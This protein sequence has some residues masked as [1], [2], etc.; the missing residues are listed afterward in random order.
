[1][2][3]V[4]IVMGVFN[5]SDT[6]SKS[7]DSIINQTFS[8]WEFII[9]DDGSTDNTYDLLLQ[10]AH[11]DPRIIIL[12]NEKNMG[13]PY[14]L[15][16]CIAHSSG[17]FI[18][19]QDGDD[20]S[21]P[22][23]LERQVKYLE[24]NK[25]CQF[26]G[27]A[28]YLFDQKGIWGE[29]I[30]K[31]SAPKPIDLRKGPNFAHPTIIFRKEALYKASLYRA[32]QDTLRVE[33]YDLYMR[34]YSLGLYGN[35]MK[36]KLYYFCEDI[37][38]YRRKKYKYRVNEALIRYKGFK[39]MNL[40]WWAYFY[41]LKPL[42]IG[43]IP[44]RIIGY[45]NHISLGLAW[46]DRE[47]RKNCHFI[48]DMII[49]KKKLL[50]GITLSEM[51]GAQKIVYYI[52]A[53]LPEESFDITLVTAPDG[54]LIKWIEELN[55][56]R[57]SPVRIQTL[58]SLQRKLSPGNDLK[59]FVAL[60]R[61]I[62]AGKYDIAHFHSSKMGILGRWAAWLAG[63]PGIFFTAHG[64]GV[65]EYQR[66]LLQ[67][68]FGWI[69]N[70]SSQLCSKVICV[71]EYDR[72]M[73]INRGWVNPAK[74]RILYNGVPEPEAI[75]GKLKNELQLNDET[76][77]I[78]TI[79]RLAEPKDPLCLIQ[80]FAELKQRAGSAPEPPLKLVII[81]DGPLR[82]NCLNLITSLGL[83]ED[84]FLLGTRDDARDLLNDF[85]IFV[86]FSKREALPVTIIEA[87]QAGKPVIAS[88]VG[89]I[90][91]LIQ[92]GING[93]LITHGAIQEGVDAIAP[94]L[95]E[96]GAAERQRLGIAG[97]KMA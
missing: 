92:N 87:M 12:K 28:V 80:V 55:Q 81:G 94:L 27:C 3:K 30:S 35:I 89:G 88:R 59:T 73:G 78:G 45:V 31:L 18:A 82:E 95:A 44:P 42:I 64:W 54:E 21:H 29:R 34:M 52:V 5:C 43:L 53:S 70:L 25:N 57:L 91:E 77:I 36:E 22:K 49:P 51:G 60:Y 8:D 20:Y 6:L 40:P 48:P 47:R 39:S 65:Y 13:L 97:Q 11:K 67:K 15:N 19:R 4:S 41:V 72:E 58:P 68:L 61:L 32:D 66:P 7:I 90:P 38:A 33:D 69:E 86:L 50:L 46:R 37:Q 96:N 84:I 79:C 17:E 16:A 75:T 23:R 56:T 2:P 9:C 1:M 24:E 10:Y 93:Y 63:T 76:L 83:S 62:K 71:S 26:V 14:G 85:D 74:V